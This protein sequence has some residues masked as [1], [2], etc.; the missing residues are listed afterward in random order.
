MIQNLTA[1][2]TDT[3][4]YQL[5]DIESRNID[6]PASLAHRSEIELEILDLFLKQ[7]R[8]DIRR[9]LKMKR[10]GINNDR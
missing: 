4:V 9:A 10:N 6:M 7:A 8:R 1:Y 3:A 2:F 5:V